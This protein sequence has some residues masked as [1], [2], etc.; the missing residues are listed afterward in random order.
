[1]NIQE[2]LSSWALPSDMADLVNAGD[3]EA[4][5]EV[6]E[7]FLED[8]RMQLEQVAAAIASRDRIRV[9]RLGH[10]LKGG[11]A[12][13]GA[14]L[15]SNIAGLLE[16]PDGEQ[17]WPHAEEMLAAEFERVESAIRSHPIFLG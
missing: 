17:V 1:M 5:R 6:L 10:S 2:N 16:S 12:Q 8:T 14:L 13:I 11:C 4:I 9:E 7:M 3:G 15:L